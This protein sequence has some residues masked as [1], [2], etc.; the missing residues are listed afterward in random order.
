MVKTIKDKFYGDYSTGD[1]ADK[2][3]IIGSS[4]ITVNTKKG[5]DSVLMSSG[6]C[7]NDTI[8]L[9]DGADILTVNK[10]AMVYDTVVRAGNGNDKV[11]V[12]GTQQGV[13]VYGDAGADVINITGEVRTKS[14]ANSYVSSFGSGYTIDGG[15]GKD[16]ITINGGT[17]FKIAGGTDNDVINVYGGSKHNVNGGSGNDVITAK[18]LKSLSNGGNNVF[19]GGVGNDTITVWN[20][21]STVKGGNGSDKIYIKGG[22]LHSVKGDAGNDTIVVSGGTNV[23]IY[24]GTGTDRITIT[25]GSKHTVSLGSGKNTVKFGNASGILGTIGTLTMGRNSV[26]NITIQWGKGTHYGKY[27][28][29]TANSVSQKSVY[30]DTLTISG[31]KSSVFDFR[32]KNSTLTMSYGAGSIVIDNFLSNGFRKGITFS[33]KTLSRSAILKKAGK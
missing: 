11:T 6:F 3:T 2:V 22:S 7:M 8:K 1:G 33:D 25:S 15:S 18:D 4:L 27:V 12:N 19:D 30:N 9:G 26:D 13:K 14:G 21:S 28:L 32:Y 10:K 16:R 31:I 24:S 5:N 23:K 17:G 29:K 20:N